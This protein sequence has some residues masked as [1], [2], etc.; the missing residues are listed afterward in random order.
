M[1]YYMLSE[2]EIE[3]VLKKGKFD[4]KENAEKLICACWTA[5][6]VLDNYL[7]N[8]EDLDYEDIKK[9]EKLYEEI[10]NFEPSEYSS[11]NVW[12]DYYRKTKNFLE[13]HRE[14]YIAK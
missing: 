13:E 6:D 10:S 2:N 9:K 8:G 14:E 12:E 7:Y 11:G 1:N 3:E 4:K 5:G